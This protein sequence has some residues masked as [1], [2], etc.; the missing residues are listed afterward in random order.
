MSEVTTNKIMRERNM[1]SHPC[2]YCETPCF[3]LQC[4]N[5]HL[6]MVAEREGD[7]VDCKNKFANAL[8][9]DGTK[10]QRCKPCQE[11]FERINILP[12]PDCNTMFDARI[13]ERCLDCYKKSFHKCEKCDKTIRGE[14]TMCSD[15]FKKQRE[16]KRLSRDTLYPSNDCRTKGCTNQTTYTFCKQ[17]N[18]AN[19]SIS[20]LSIIN[21][22]QELGCSINYKGNYKYCESHS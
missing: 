1:E 16:E 18:D 8:R 21:R 17:C 6:K 13:F 22:C 20:S 5:C 15:C 12:C 11:E 7:C 3:G 4:K 10:K 19:R 14:Y 9:R 2:Q